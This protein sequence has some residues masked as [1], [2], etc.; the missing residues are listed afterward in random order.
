MTRLKVLSV[1]FCTDATQTPIS[2]NSLQQPQ[3]LILEDKSYD[4]LIKE[5]WLTMSKT[6]PDTVKLMVT[7]QG[8][9]NLILLDSITAPSQRLVKLKNQTFFYGFPIAQPEII[10]VTGIQEQES[11]NK[12]HVEFTYDWKLD[13]LG[14]KFTAFEPNNS[15]VDLIKKDTTLKGT[16]IFEKYDDG[17]RLSK[18]GDISK[19]SRRQQQ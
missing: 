10:E 15:M 9:N 11:E 18:L 5:G 1:T 7:E 4:F 8:K 14:N 2:V 17:W 19:V 3:K 13:E 16:A 12:A 6:A